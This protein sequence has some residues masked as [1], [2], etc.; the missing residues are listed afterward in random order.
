MCVNIALKTVSLLLLGTLLLHSSDSSSTFKIHLEIFRDYA[1][2]IKTATS[3]EQSEPLFK[4]VA[5]KVISQNHCPLKNKS[6]RK[7]FQKQTCS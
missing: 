2:N 6:G 5:G 4:T 7:H 3:I 1:N